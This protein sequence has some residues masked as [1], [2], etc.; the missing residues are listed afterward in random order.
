MQID[1]SFV[2]QTSRP[3]LVDVSSR[4]AMN[5]AAAIGD[6]NAWYLDDTRAGGAIAPPML[7]VALTWPLSMRF[8]EF[9]EMDGFPIEVLTRQVHYTEALEFVRPIRP[10]DRLSIAGEIAAITS[11]PGGTYIVMCY[12]AQ[13]AQD[14][15]VFTEYIGGLLRG[16]KCIGEDRYSLDCPAIVR[17]HDEVE[18]HW[19]ESIDISP[20]SAH[21]YDGCTDIIF[22]IHT[23]AAFAKAVG[24]PGIILQG[25]ATLAIAV[26]EALNREGGG[27]PT[28]VAGIRCGFKNMVIPGTRIVIRCFGETVCAGFR[29]VNFDVLNVDGKSAIAGGQL[30]LRGDA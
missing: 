17:R 24:L 20:V 16:V 3:Y 19:E 1:T 23:S 9:W 14:E 8:Q 11:H 2:G 18:P 25:T 22:P 27:D 13:D 28:L 6:A 26:K 7:A 4:Q 15:T 30:L 29:S 12:I 5:Y 10:D 21:V